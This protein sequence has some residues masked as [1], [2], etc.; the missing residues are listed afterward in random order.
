MPRSASP[1]RCRHCASEPEVREIEALYLR[2]IALARRW[3]YVENQYF[4]APSVYRALAQ[5][6]AEADGPEILVVCPLHSGGRADRL[7]MDRAR[8]AQVKRLRAADRY[9][10]F[11]AVAPLTAAGESIIVHSKIMVID[12]RLFRVG[13]ANLNCRSLGL[14]TECDLCIEADE[15]DDRIGRD[16]LKLLSRLLSESLGCDA[17]RV[18]EEIRRA[19]GL[20][21]A[22]DAIGSQSGRR[23]QDVAL[24]PLG[25]VDRFVARRHLYDPAGAADNWRPWRR[26][27]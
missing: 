26:P 13:S 7:S 27:A 3:I 12:T 21:G 1:A 20:L 5:R 19:G 2:A 11:R 10:R 14:D 15:N 25:L 23:L 24:E 18:E 17:A 4:T 22:C 6:L 9:R 8:N 16:I